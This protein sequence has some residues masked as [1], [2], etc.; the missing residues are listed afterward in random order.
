MYCD[1]SD[2]DIKIYFIRT[3]AAGDLSKLIICESCKSVREADFK[4]G[5]LKRYQFVPLDDYRKSL[6]QEGTKALNRF[7]ELFESK[8]RGDQVSS[9]SLDI[10]GMKLILNALNYDVALSPPELLQENI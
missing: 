1:G 6:Y 3:P 2:A 8:K 7:F 4:K 5:S 9:D 10:E